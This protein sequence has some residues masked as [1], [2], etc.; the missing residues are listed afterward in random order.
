MLSHNK[1]L[2]LSSWGLMV[3]LVFYFYFF[4]LLAASLSAGSERCL[5]TCCVIV[6]VINVCLHN[7]TVNIIFLINH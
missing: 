6:L 5:K 1:L 4:G 2:K 3:S 7:K